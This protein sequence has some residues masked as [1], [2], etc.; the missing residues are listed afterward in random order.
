MIC[1][2][3]FVCKLPSVF[4]TR[5][6][7]NTLR[8]SNRLIKPS[9]LANIYFF[10]K[11]RILMSPTAWKP[12]CHPDIQHVPRSREIKDVNEGY[13]QFSS[14]GFAKIVRN[15]RLTGGINFIYVIKTR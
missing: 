2:N 1:K 13:T 5:Y 6:E 9:R 12:H 11:H 3:A 8:R 10:I 15:E 7:V 14:M 4:I